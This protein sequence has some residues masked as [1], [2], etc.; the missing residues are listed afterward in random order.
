MAQASAQGMQVGHDEFMAMIKAQN[1]QCALA[2]EQRPR[3]DQALAGVPFS[4]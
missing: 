2:V 3:N 4:V 1:E